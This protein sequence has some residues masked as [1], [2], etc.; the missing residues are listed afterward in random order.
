MEFLKRYLTKYFEQ[1]FVLLVLVSIALINYYSPQKLAFLNFYFIPVILGAYYL[2]RRMAVLGAIM[3]LL[4][5][6]WYML[7]E[8]QAFVSEPSEISTYWHIG[9]WSGFLI[10]A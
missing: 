8:P 10:L 7:L 2:G 9:V 6:V 3:C 4:M 5:V 1:V